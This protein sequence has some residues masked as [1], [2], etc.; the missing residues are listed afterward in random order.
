MK[1]QISLILGIIC[2]VGMLIGFIPCFGWFNWFNIPLA[3]IGLVFGIREYNNERNRIP[4]DEYGNPVHRPQ[5]LPL[6]IIFCSIALVL[7]F[8]RLIL[9]GGIL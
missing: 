7:G 9:G 3:V 5:Q 1:K 2:I 6:G 8:I 4:K